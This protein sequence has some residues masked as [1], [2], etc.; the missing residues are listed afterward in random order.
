[1]EQ[2]IGVIL[3]AVMMLGFLALMVWGPLRQPTQRDAILGQRQS[4]A[5]R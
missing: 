1:M 5:V 2:V 3:L 4:G